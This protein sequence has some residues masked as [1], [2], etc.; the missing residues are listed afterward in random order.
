MT[1]YDLLSDL[2]MGKEFKAKYKG[3]DCILRYRTRKTAQVEL[4]GKRSVFLV[5]CGSSRVSFEELE[6]I[7]DI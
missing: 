5:A 6:N 3:M 2:E 1:E 7:E 4:I